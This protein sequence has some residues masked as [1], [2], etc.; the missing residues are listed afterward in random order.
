MPMGWCCA[1]GMTS[2]QAS[3]GTQASAT[4]LMAVLP[5]CYACMG[6]WGQAHALAGSTN[7][8]WLCQGL[9][10]GYPDWQ[11]CLWSPW[12]LANAAEPNCLPTASS[13]SPMALAG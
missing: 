11:H 13:A 3:A 10:Q 12:Q 7:G 8:S 9:P 6:C 1:M 5:W 2:C 4:T